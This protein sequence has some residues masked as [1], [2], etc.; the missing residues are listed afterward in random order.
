MFQT[1]ESCFSSN[2]ELVSFSRVSIALYRENRQAGTLQNQKLLKEK[3]KEK[4]KEIPG[5]PK[6]LT[7]RKIAVSVP[8][9]H[10]SECEGGH[11]AGER[12]LI[13]SVSQGQVRDGVW[14]S[15]YNQS[16][17]H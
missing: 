12:N 9:H 14:G 1:L 17:S 2:K 3:V 6:K 10:V 8:W 11:F 7:K 4:L 16:P 13:L 15:K 5:L